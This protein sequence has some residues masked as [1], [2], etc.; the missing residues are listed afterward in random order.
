MGE[1]KK[2]KDLIYAFTALT[3]IASL[4]GNATDNK[5]VSPLDCE[6]QLADH[7]TAHLTLVQVDPRELVE[8][9]FG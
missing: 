1:L 5:Y 8:I 6:N 7:L 9:C 2:R 4:P 3:L